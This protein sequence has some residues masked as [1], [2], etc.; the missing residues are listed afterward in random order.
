MIPRELECRGVWPSVLYGTG[1]RYGRQ[2]QT[3]TPLWPEA[4]HLLSLACTLHDPAFRKATVYLCS[5]Y[6]RLSRSTKIEGRNA[7]PHERRSLIAG[8]TACQQHVPV[9]K[10]R[11][12]WAATDLE[13]PLEI[14][15]GLHGGAS[16]VI[17]ARDR[18]KSII[19]SESFSHDF[20]DVRFFFNFLFGPV[21]LRSQ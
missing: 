11:L 18:S 15:L 17:L 21:W 20:C 8:C 5:K 7:V 13:C 12:P 1:T 10:I 3:S 14:M 4:G 16:R 9:L 6:A 2:D 19:I